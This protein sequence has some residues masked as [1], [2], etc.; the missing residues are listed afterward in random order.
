MQST[1]SWRTRRWAIEALTVEET[2]KGSTPMS[3]SRVKAPAASL[4]CRVEKTR[5]PVSDA[6]IAI[7]AVSTSRISPTMMT[8]GSWRR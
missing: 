5:W 4:V 8:S 3:V 1:Q 2:K 6:W 7:S